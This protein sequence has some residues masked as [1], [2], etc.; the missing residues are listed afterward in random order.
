MA[1][2]PPTV[3]FVAALGLTLE[4]VVAPV[5]R[6]LESH[7]FRRVAVAGRGSVPP[8][9]RRSFDEVHEITPFRR[10]GL[11]GLVRAGRDLA[12]IVRDE[13]PALLHL[14]TPYAIA[15]G[16]VVAR[17]TRTRHL[18]VVHGTLFGASGR[19]GRIFAAVES[20]S[21]RFTPWYVTENPD[22]QASYRRL[23]PRSE[24]RL[25]PCGGAGVDVVGLRAARRLVGEGG[26]GAPRV[27]IMGRLTPDKNLDLAV[28]AWRLA[29]QTRPDLQ[30]RIVGSTV[31]REPSWAPPEEAG[32]VPTGWTDD[33]AAEL[34]A[35]DVVLLTSLREGFPLVVTEALVVG[36]PVVGVDNRG[37]RA[38]ARHV[39]EG[40]LLAPPDA[41]ALSL[42]LLAQLRARTVQIR[43]ESLRA[44]QREDVAAFHADQILEAVGGVGGTAD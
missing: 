28:A 27:L 32:I 5:S 39:R 20:A 44:W 17:A 19:S 13:R 1:Q 22:D 8:S 36:T 6:A 35:A 9:L 41:T 25:A 42:A 12:R 4:G 26:R 7:G 3:L 31:A 16:R 11:G 30:L 18:A 37:T 15:L 43:P 21:A 34:A 33:P 40:L 23:A 24:V 10:A 2:P 14:H 38:V 29:R